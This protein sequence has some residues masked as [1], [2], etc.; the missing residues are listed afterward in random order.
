MCLSQ[1]PQLLCGVAGKIR[2]SLAKGYGT[3]ILSQSPKGCRDLDWQ[4]RVLVGT[5]VQLGEAKK[6]INKER[7]M[8][9]NIAKIEVWAPHRLAQNCLNDR[10]FWGGLGTFP[11]S[12]GNHSAPSHT[13][14]DPVSLHKC[15]IPSTEGALMYFSISSLSSV[16]AAHIGFAWEKVNS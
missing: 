2:R 10:L 4:S 15:T 5:L 14:T 8:R 16:S 11:E 3:R 12:S 13:P 7:R 9:E 1:G 6:L